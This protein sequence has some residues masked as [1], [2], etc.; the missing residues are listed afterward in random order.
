LQ[1]IQELKYETKI[2]GRNTIKVLVPRA[3]RQSVMTE[4][5]EVF[6]DRGFLYDPIRGSSLGQLKKKD[7]TGSVTILVKPDSSKGCAANTGADYE[8]QKADYI[9]GKYNSLGVNV[10]TAGFSHGSDLQI[11]SKENTL[12]IELKT[13]CGADYGQFTLGFNIQ[14]GKWCPIKTKGFRKNEAIFSSLYQD[15]LSE[16]LDKRALFRD[17]SD[18]CLHIKGN[19]I[20]GLKPSMRTGEF[21]DKLNR[22]WFGEKSDFKAGIDFANIA[23]YYSSKGDNFIQIRGK[24]LYSFDEER[25]FG[26]PLFKGSGEKAN[27]RFRVKP[28]MSHNGRHSFTAA[29]KLSVRSSTK[30]LDSDEDLDS[31]M[32]EFT[33]T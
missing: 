22:E 9:Q 1:A 16:Y 15:Y 4:M 8:K 27:V 2:V 33:G 11:I 23:T 20:V 30:D 26:A 28:H 3:A 31:I 24:G 17:I 6:I 32:K 14:T 29:I 19:I 13:S 7:N 10:Q 18:E 5:R 21:R 25:T 12:N